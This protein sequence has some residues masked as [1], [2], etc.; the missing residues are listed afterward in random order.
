VDVSRLPIGPIFKGQAAQEAWQL[1]TGPTGHPETSVLN[2][3]TPRKIPED[4][5]T[6]FNRGRNIRSRI[7]FIAVH[8]IW[9]FE[10]QTKKKGHNT[11]CGVSILC[12]WAQVINRIGTLDHKGI[13]VKYCTSTFTAKENSVLTAAAG[14]PYHT[15][16]GNS[17]RART[18]RNGTPCSLYYT[19][20][21]TIGFSAC[22][23]MSFGTYITTFRTSS[24]SC[25][26]AEIN[27]TVSVF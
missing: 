25:T 14:F 22:Y 26:V 27:T 24:L 17:C 12:P 9:N 7:I 4:G 23:A 21:K 15:A 2:R 19:T 3:L 10:H 11:K 18:R 16:P 5:G 8:V 20:Y 1:M 6:H 13:S